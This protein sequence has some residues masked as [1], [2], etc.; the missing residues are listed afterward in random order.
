MSEESAWPLAGLRILDLSSGIAGPYATKLLADAGA[1]VVKLESPRDGDALRR[2]SASGQPLADG[3]DGA[4]FQHL[5]AT[6][7]SACVDLSQR[8]GRQKL[9]DWA[10]GADL[11]FESFEPGTLDRLGVG[12]EALQTRNRALSLVSVTPWGTGGPW[13]GR[14]ASEFTLQAAT[15]STD[16][17]GLDSRGPVAAGGRIGEWV[18]GTY[19]ALGGL[20]AWLSARGTGRGQHVDLSSFEAML[21][22]MTYYHD[23]SGQWRDTKLNRSVEVPSIEPARDGWVGLC[24]LTGQQWQDFCTMI[25]QPE[26][27]ED[28][29]YLDGWLRSQQMERMQRIIHGWTREHTVAEIVELASLMRIPAAPIGDGSNLPGC[30]H[31][32]T[33]GTF[34]TGPGDFIRPRPPFLLEKSPLRPFGPAP[35]LG[36]HGDELAAEAA[37]PRREPDGGPALPLAGLEVLELSTF[38]AG[39]VAGATLA[40]MGANVIKLESIQ[41]PDGMRFAGAI[42]G[43]RLWEWSPVFHGVN[44]GKRSLTLRLDDE[45]GRA[46]FE[47]LVEQSDVVLENFSAR[48]MENF[49]LGWER[50]HRLNPRAIMVRMPAFGLDGPWRDRAGF[51]M[52]V[53][54]ASGLAWITG[55]EDL[56]LVMRGVCDPIGGIN[57]VIA[58]LL[59]LE[60]R[61][62]TGEGQLVEVPLVEGA[63]NLA[64][65][66]VVEHSAYGALLTRAGNRGPCAAPQGVYRCAG[67]DAHLALAVA[68]DEQWRALRH[69]MGDPDWAR[70][71]ALAKAAGRH[72]GHDA[73]D[74]RLAAWLATQERDDVAER[75]L[76]AGVPA[77]PLVN[78]HRLMPNPQLEQRGFF[79]IME[80]P[81]TGRTRYPGLPM[82]FSALPR[83]LHPGPPPTLGQHNDEI[84]KEK[85]GLSDEELS[86]LRE[87]QIIGERPAF[88]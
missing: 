32:V 58:L 63:L 7:R 20:L 66:Q 35:K 6:K 23:L 22:S 1:D 13:A 49:G 33:R 40:D 45:D 87:R 73:I 50:I 69:Q 64:A 68:T 37:R 28:E 16:H 14:P 52:T 43:E 71:P 41:R 75:L 81:V 78:G 48:V 70:D 34:V 3:E 55:Y 27:G 25:G 31:F 29:R 76:A 79:Q 61:R 57:A 88:M 60:H 51:A 8:A 86:E 42:P 19:A 4:L 24:T 18:A 77:N 15:G 62:Q 47:R 5:N 17:R 2:W 59:A 83:Q 9:L 44:P 53:E 10:D 84:L 65:E 74:E 82:A 26:L 72:A 12:V 36:E 38:W 11:A 67:D 56:P 39:P 54:Q 85:L 46:L 80:H 30:D 21:L